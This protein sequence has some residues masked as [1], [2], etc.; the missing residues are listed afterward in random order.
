M[1]KTRI[2]VAFALTCLGVGGWMIR[3]AY[4]LLIVGAVVWLELVLWGL[5]K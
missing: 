1:T 3:P 4:G 5:R 2:I